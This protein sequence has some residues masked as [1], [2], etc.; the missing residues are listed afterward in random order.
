M[1]Y[2]LTYFTAIL[3][4]QNYDTSINRQNGGSVSVDIILCNND[5]T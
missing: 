5:K 4:V 3:T 2:L 1:F